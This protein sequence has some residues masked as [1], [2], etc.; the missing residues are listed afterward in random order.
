MAG[1][2]APLD[3]VTSAAGMATQI[4]LHGA[5]TGVEYLDYAGAAIAW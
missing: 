2:N 5:G 1:E 4:E 3:V